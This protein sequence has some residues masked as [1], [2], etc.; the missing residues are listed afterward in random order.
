MSSLAVYASLL[1]AA[2]LLVPLFKRLG[3]GSV[4]GYLVAGVLIGP[5]VIGVVHEPEAI[6]HTAEL[7]V[8]LLMFVIG[9]ELQRERLWALRKSVFGL[10]AMQ[11]LG[12]GA[13]LTLAAWFAGLSLTTAALVGI[14]LAMTSTAFLLPF[15]AERGELDTQYGRES[16]AVLLFQ[17][18]SVIPI[19]AIVAIL[20]AASGSV[21]P[22]GWP[23]LVAIVAVIGLGKPVLS[24]MFKY[25][26]RFG[27]RDIF[28][29]A[30]LLTTV[31]LAWLMG[32]VGLP[33]TLGA[34]L[35]GVLLAESQFRHELEAS[36]EPFEALLL[37]LFF[38][39]VGMSVNLQLLAAKPLTVLSIA[40]GAFAIKAISFY[41]F[42]RFFTGAKDAIARPQALALAVGG[43]FAFVLFT[44][45]QGAKLLSTDEA[46]LLT[47]AVAITM[48]AAPL[49]WMLHD[50][51][52]VP[53]INRNTEAAPFDRIDDA[54]TPVIIAGFG[55]V[56]QIVGRVLNARNITFTALDAASDHVD[57]VRKFGNKIYY[58]D[59]TK[60]DLLRAAKTSEAKLFVVCVDDVDASLTIVNLVRKQ[61]PN[62][63]VLAR[64]RNRN[65]ALKLK[66]LGVDDPVRE[67]FWSSIELTKSVL[68]SLDQ[69]PEQIEKTIASFVAHDLDLLEKQ[70]AVF[71]DEEKLIAMSKG[72]RAELDNILREDAVADGRSDSQAPEQQRT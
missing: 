35:A 49:V 47:L 44:A 36:I 23:A 52:I 45:A 12:C 61:F 56:G 70:Q 50:K 31:G 38:M 21:K 27:S 51:L 46:E 64:A 54:A 20:G 15:L 63:K 55:R 24:L 16:F 71:E 67:T 6:L 13:V 8:T 40:V 33:A 10:G 26:S 25:V 11:V 62:V 3:V 7:G 53:W 48:A 14:A 57:S 34:F 39:A 1:A 60:F 29:A 59:A 5:S 69:S 42:R 41:V 37:G 30:A 43:E 72:A 17:D 68:Q 58:G 32:A 66:Q 65:H 9:L 22:P 4:L 2:V 18:L 19:L 28:T